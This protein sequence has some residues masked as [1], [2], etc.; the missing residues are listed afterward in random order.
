M[1]QQFVYELKKYIPRPEMIDLFKIVLTEAWYDQTNHLQDDRKQLL[2][3]IKEPEGKISY[4]R[5]L[6]SSKQIDP[7]DFLEMKTEYSAKLEKLGAKLSTY[8]H[9]HVDIKDL[10]AKGIN[11]LLKLDNLYETADIEKKREIISSMYPE[12]M[13]FNGFSF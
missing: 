6:L 8:N 10:L 3:Q 7:S 13:T 1:N 9:D 12:K 11:N 5:D 2:L 4:I